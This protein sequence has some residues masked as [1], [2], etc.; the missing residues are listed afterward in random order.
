VIVRRRLRRAQR[1]IDSYQRGHVNGFADGVNWA[2][3]RLHWSNPE[4]ADKL[5]EAWRNGMADHDQKKAGAAL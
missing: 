3:D 2:V 5:I 4:L 1:E